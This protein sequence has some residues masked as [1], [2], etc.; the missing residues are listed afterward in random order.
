MKQRPLR[1]TLLFPSLS[2]AFKIATETKRTVYDS[3][4]LALAEAQGFSLVTADQRFYNALQTTRHVTAR[5]FS[6]LTIYRFFCPTLQGCI[7]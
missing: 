6:G 7:C 4:Y 3:L 1:T 5:H 2:D